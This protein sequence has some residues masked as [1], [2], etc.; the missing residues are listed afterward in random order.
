M[1]LFVSLKSENNNS[2]SFHFIIT[3][4]GSNKDKTLEVQ[5]SPFWVWEKAYR[6]LSQY[7]LQKK[8]CYKAPTVH[9]VQGGA[10]HT[11]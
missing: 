3:K 1:L 8:V 10:G 4:E 2:C 7:I 6:N 9:E 11:L 5:I